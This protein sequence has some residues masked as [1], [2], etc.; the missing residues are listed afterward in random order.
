MGPRQLSNHFSV[1]DFRG[2]GLEQWE[3]E[4]EIETITNYD[5]MEE[6]LKTCDVLY[7]NRLQK[8]RQSDS[9]LFKPFVLDDKWMAVLNKDAIILNP[10]PR[11]E[12]MPAKYDGDFR[13][14]YWEQMKNGLYMR[15]AVLHWI[16]I[17]AS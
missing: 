13:N 5:Q 3:P 10:G 2:K 1:W 12:E 14:K 4:A 15:M 17:G 8:E 9:R 16:F 7:M 11:Q 6:A